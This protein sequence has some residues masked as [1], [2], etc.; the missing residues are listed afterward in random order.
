M[1]QQVV[2]GQQQ[3]PKE[4]FAETHLLKPLAAE[5]QHAHRPLGHHASCIGG[6]CQ[7]VALSKVL[8][9]PQTEEL[10]HRS[11]RHGKN[12]CSCSLS[13]VGTVLLHILRNQ[14]ACFLISSPWKHMQAQAASETLR[15]TNRQQH[16]QCQ[17]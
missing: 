10:Q 11:W 13:M 16:S 12:R 2:H 9:R 14:H 6:V 5:T 7:Q 1:D 4:G 8:P 3:A 15:I 17:A